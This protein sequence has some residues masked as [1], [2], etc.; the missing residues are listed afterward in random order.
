MK[1]MISGYIVDIAISYTAWC[2]KRLSEVMSKPAFC[3]WET[4]YRNDPKFSGRL[5][6]ANSA[7]PDQTA[8]RGAVW[9]GSSLFAVPF[10]SFWHNTL[11]F[12]LFV[13]FASFWHNTL[14]FGLFVCILGRLQQSFLASE[15]LGTLRYHIRSIYRTCSNKPTPRSFANNLCISAH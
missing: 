5:V 15:N 13:P 1:N 14:R 10:A 2:H 11:R 12:G 8:P 9:S 6:W 7:D 3:T 4:T